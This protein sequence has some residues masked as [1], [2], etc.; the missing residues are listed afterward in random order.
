MKRCKGILRGFILSKDFLDNYNRFDLLLSVWVDSLMTLVEATGRIFPGEGS[1]NGNFPFSESEF[2][3]KLE[4]FDMSLS[5][6][7]V[8]IAAIIG[9]VL[10]CYWLNAPWSLAILG[11]VSFV[12]IGFINQIVSLVKG[13]MKK[14]DLSKEGFNTVT[15]TISESVTYI[16]SQYVQRRFL[17]KYQRS[18]PYHSSAD[19]P[20]LYDRRRQ[21]MEELPS[22][23]LNRIDT[24]TVECD[25]AVFKRKSVLYSYWKPTSSPEQPSQRQAGHNF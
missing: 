4:G 14:P 24:I 17:I 25:N 21:S 16:R 8:I 20:A 7:A 11:I 13:L 6:A 22:D 18:N 5:K 1:L 3:S 15:Q 19:D 2:K 12:C 23:I 10:I 9:T